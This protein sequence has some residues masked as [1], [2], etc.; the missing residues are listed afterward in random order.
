V[1]VFRERIAARPGEKLALMPDL[2]K[3]H[4]FDAASG[5]RL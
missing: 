2:S 3:I 1:G 4:L 5:L